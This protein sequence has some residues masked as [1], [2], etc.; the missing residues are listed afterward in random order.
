[1][2]LP[3]RATYLPATA[4]TSDAFKLA[5]ELK[6]SHYILQDVDEAL[7]A[8]DETGT[9]WNM[10]APPFPTPAPAPV[11]LSTERKNGPLRASSFHPKIL[12]ERTRFC[13][14]LVS[15]HALVADGELEPKAL[16]RFSEIAAGAEKHRKSSLGHTE[17]LRMKGG[18]T[19]SDIGEHTAAYREMESQRV[20]ASIIELDFCS[21]DY[22]QQETKRL[23]AIADRRLS[24]ND[25]NDIRL[26]D[27]SYEETSLF[28]IECAKW[29]SRRKGTSLPQEVIDIVK[30]LRKVTADFESSNASAR[31][32]SLI[33]AH[34]RITEQKKLFDQFVE[35]NIQRRKLD[36]SELRE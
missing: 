27:F 22:I 7:I 14:F 28:W 32:K 36:I 25:P 10:P 29:C 24:D 31:A 34:V 8:Q 13:H 18:I 9:G 21:S 16:A 26:D 11:R 2:P 15:T 23:T 20:I 1:M 12:H 30:R 3:K 19:Q 5:R 6:D 35:K 4:M 33:L 17:F